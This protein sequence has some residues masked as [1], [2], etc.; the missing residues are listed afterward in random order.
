MSTAARQEILAGYAKARLGKRRAEAPLLPFEPAPVRASPVGA[1]VRGKGAKTLRS[2]DLFSGAGGLTIGLDA[3][4]FEPVF[5]VESDED[6]C[7][8]FAGVFPHAHVTPRPVEEFNF[9]QFEGIDLV[10]PG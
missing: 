7:L 8:T 4:G 1:P 5:A 9:R 2:L 10:A 6:A 3:A